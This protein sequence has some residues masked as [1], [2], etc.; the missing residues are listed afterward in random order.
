MPTM[1]PKT[2]FEAILAPILVRLYEVLGLDEPAK[3]NVVMFSRIEGAPRF[4]GDQDVVLRVS[5]ARNLPGFMEGHGIIAP[6]IRR[7]L[8]VQC[9]T[10]QS[11]DVSDRIDNWLLNRQLPFEDQIL[12]ALIGFFPK[13]DDEDVLTIHELR[14]EDTQAYRDELK[15]IPPPDPTWGSSILVFAVDYNPTAPDLPEPE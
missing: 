5:G 2:P 11:V 9:R 7:G 4:Q 12:F 6:G 14:L 3:Q 15:L 8:I 13:N 10:R 1:G